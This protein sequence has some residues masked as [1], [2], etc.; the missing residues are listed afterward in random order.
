[1]RK[2]EQ[3]LLEG[4]SET[5]LATAVSNLSVSDSI[6]DPDDRSV[7]QEFIRWVQ[8]C[9]HHFPVL[10]Q[11]A[12]GDMRPDGGDASVWDRLLEAEDL[13]SVTDDLLKEYPNAVDLMKGQLERLEL[14]GVYWES[15]DR[16]HQRY[17]EALMTIG[18]DD[19][20]SYVVING[21]MLLCN[22]SAEIDRVIG[23]HIA[24]LQSA[25]LRL[26]PTLKWPHR[27]RMTLLLREAGAGVDDILGL[28]LTQ[29]LEK[30]S[31]AERVQYV[32]FLTL[33]DD[34]ESEQQVLK[35][36]RKELE[37]FEH[38]EHQLVLLQLAANHVRPE[39]YVEHELSM[40][41]SYGIRIPYH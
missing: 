6:A 26:W 7:T 36:L 21:R 2:I 16:R 38:G 31:L 22:T 23:P 12:I 9:A 10:L 3:V 39:H 29:D 14:G 25:L 34:D 28:A 19:C 11:A 40:I 24:G 37:R 20:F 5:T 35:V 1:M 30:L 18:D 8:W 41:Q 27:T 33:F 13:R 32:Q 17:V 4:W 15:M